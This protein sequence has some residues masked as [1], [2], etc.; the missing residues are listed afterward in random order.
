LLNG[1]LA[2]TALWSP[3]KKPLLMK[4]LNIAMLIIALVV[5]VFA[6]Q[7]GITGGEIRHPEIE[8]GNYKK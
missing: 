7:T 5:S 6:Y 4:K 8:Q 2:I 3:G 1:T